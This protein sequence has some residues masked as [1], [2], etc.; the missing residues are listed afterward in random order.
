MKNHENQQQKTNDETKK[1]EAEEEIMPQM[2]LDSWIWPS[3]VTLFFIDELH[4][5][6]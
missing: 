6:V 2:N 4:S 5:N 3:P 1:E